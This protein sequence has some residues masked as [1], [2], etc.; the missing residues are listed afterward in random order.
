MICVGCGEEE[1]HHF[2]EDGGMGPYGPKC[3]QLLIEE[4]R[5]AAARVPTLPPPPEVADAAEGAQT[6]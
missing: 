1:G 5:K 4:D 2:Y 3:M 6:R